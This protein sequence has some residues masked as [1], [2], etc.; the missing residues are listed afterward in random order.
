MLLL[1]E[2]DE[3]EKNKLI[4]EAY[5]DFIRGYNLADDKLKNEY[6]QK[7]INLAKDDYKVAKKI[8]DEMG[9]KY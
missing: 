8:C 4:E 1:S 7:I 9:W 6:K 5:N 3:K 2:E